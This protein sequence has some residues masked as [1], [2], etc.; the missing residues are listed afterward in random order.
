[1]SYE[2]SDMKHVALYAAY[3]AVMRSSPLIANPG[4][5]E[6]VLQHRRPNEQ[7]VFSINTQDDPS[8]IE[9]LANAV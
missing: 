6:S 8:R 5:I 2:R 9:N 4:D 1:M 3:R 7:K